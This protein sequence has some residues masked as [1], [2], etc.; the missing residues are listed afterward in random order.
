MLAYADETHREHRDDPVTLVF[1]GHT[2]AYIGH[3]HAEGLRALD[4]A[5]ALSPSSMTALRSS[6]WI[7]CYVGDNTVS[8]EQLQRAMALNPLDPEIASVLC[9]LSYAHLGAGDAD[10]AVDLA[11]RGLAT[12]PL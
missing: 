6:V 9:G 4:I 1:A 8:I 10:R 12:Q 5:L 2:L 7:Q 3:R 11:R